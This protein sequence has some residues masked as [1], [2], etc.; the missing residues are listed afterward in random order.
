MKTLHLTELY[1]YSPHR[2]AGYAEDV[3]SHGKVEGDRLI[4]S[5]E[6]Y[7]R[8]TAKYAPSGEAL[9]TPIS[10]Q[11]REI[12]K[13]CDQAKDQAFICRLYRGCCF[14]RWRTQPLSQCPAS[15]PKWL[16]NPLPP[17]FPAQIPG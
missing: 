2:P 4:L 6:A 15:P 13:A 5:D 1:A 10:K 7:K 8:L 14:G 12:C 9:E 11:R 3:I 16:A 17:V